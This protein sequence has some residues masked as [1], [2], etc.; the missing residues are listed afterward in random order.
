MLVMG[1]TLVSL[2]KLE[3]L[4]LKT[5]QKRKKLQFRRLSEGRFFKN[6]RSLE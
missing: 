6:Y 4:S 5:T 3:I 1:T 2:L